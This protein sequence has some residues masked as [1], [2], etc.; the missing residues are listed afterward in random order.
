MTLTYFNA[1][2]C[3]IGTKQHVNLSLQM[4]VACKAKT[5]KRRKKKYIGNRALNPDSVPAIYL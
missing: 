1:V 5:C 3:I 2:T 4:G